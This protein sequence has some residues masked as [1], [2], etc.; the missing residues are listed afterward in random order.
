ML[1]AF[2]TTVLCGAFLRPTGINYRLL[3]L[4]AQPRS[5]LDGFVTDV[6]GMEFLIRAV[7]RG[8]SGCTYEYA[9][10]QAFWD[11]FSPLLDPPAIRQAPVGRALSLRPE[12]LGRPL[13][14]VVYELTGKDRSAL[15]AEVPEQ[16]RVEVG[17]FEEKDV[18][19]AAAAIQHGAD[20]ICTSNTR[21]DFTMR[22]IG[23]VEI[24]TPTRLGE[25]YGV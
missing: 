9:D 5:P 21:R 12:L 13:G 2:D 16:A 1:V 15:L 11:V 22:H 18:H 7:D 24:F 17:G 23:S 8:L 4:A 3:E 10:A 20:G 19:L 6:V 25:E 14:E